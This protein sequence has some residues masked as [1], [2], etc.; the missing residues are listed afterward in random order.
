MRG[1]SYLVSRQPTSCCAQ[2]TSSLCVGRFRESERAVVGLR[3]RDGRGTSP[4]AKPVISGHIFLVYL[5]LITSLQIVS[6][7]TVTLKLRFLSVDFGETQ[8]NSIA[9]H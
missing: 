4:G 7:N 5:S 3:M 8:P 1:L 2:K 6:A 9:S